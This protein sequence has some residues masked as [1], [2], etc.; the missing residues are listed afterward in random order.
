MTDSVGRF[1][2]KIDTVEHTLELNPRADP[3][4]KFNFKYKTL[5]ENQFQL[6]GIIKQDSVRIIFDRSANVESE[7]LLTNRGFHWVNEYPFN[8]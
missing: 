5:V 7:I 2:S 1:F 4:L 8:K 6:S 3:R